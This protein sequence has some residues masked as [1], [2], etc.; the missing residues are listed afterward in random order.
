MRYDVSDGKV[1]AK[2]PLNLEW[3]NG[4]KVLPDGK[5]VAVAT[6]HGVEIYEMETSRRI[7][8]L[9]KKIVVGMSVSSDGAWLATTGLAGSVG[10]NIVWDIQNHR[11]VWKLPQLEGGVAFSPDDSELAISTRRTSFLKTG[12]WELLSEQGEHHHQILAGEIVDDHI[13]TGE[14]E[15]SR[16]LEWDLTTGQS[17]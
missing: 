3:V 13:W 16:L 5:L 15:G 12:S 7:V 1:T 4:L 8:T 6:E 9:G 17:I 10:D 11:Q 14:S 2:V